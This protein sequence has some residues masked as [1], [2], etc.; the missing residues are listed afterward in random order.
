MHKDT[1]IYTQG[2]SQMSKKKSLV[3]IAKLT[4]AIKWE[5]AMWNKFSKSLDWPPIPAVNITDRHNTVWN[6]VNTFGPNLH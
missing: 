3:I 1:L 5:I 4:E 2:N 6:T